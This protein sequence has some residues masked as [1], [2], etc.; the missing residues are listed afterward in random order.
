MGAVLDTIYIKELISDPVTVNSDYETD[1]VDISFREA[2]FSIQ[3]VYEN[4]I[5]VDMSLWIEVS[6]DNVNFSRVTDSDQVITDS[7]G[8]H[9]WDIV[10]GSGATFLRVGI[11]ARTG[12]IDV[13]K[14]SLHAKRRH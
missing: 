13:Q 12:S 4:G 8:S 3:L 6:N 7:I 5:N 9:F 11:E 14:I 2:E 10:G 1:S